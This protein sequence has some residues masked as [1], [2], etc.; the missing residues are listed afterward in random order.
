[1]SLLDITKYEKLNEYY[2]IKNLYEKEFNL[3]KLDLIKNKNLTW[4]EKRVQLTKKK[5]KCVNCKRNVGTV[6][7]R[8]FDNNT[9]FTNLKSY[10]GDISNPCPLKINI[11]I[12]FVEYIPD[13]IKENT[14]EIN[15]LKNSIIKYKNDIVFGYLKDPNINIDKIT[16]DLDSL[17]DTNNFYK[18][19]LLNTEQNIDKLNELNNLLFNY[20][21]IITE[22]K[23]S[24]KLFKQTNNN[25]DILKSVNNYID[26]LLPNIQKIEKLKYK[27]RNVEITDDTFELVQKTFDNDD[28]EIK[29]KNYIHIK[30]FI[31]G[32]GEN[33]NKNNETKKIRKNVGI[34]TKKT[35]K[36]ISSM[37]EQDNE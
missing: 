35:K 29:G 14:N 21:N 15:N 7:L 5:P 6:F 9:L 20:Y 34:K 3:I 33:I 11:D 30:S 17:I 31:T 10:C 32:L 19:N 37:L 18:N 28:L 8:S 27:Y 13:V 36:N 12:E 16:N 1:M 4:N 25:D 2:F 23:N 26:N 22:I 24:M